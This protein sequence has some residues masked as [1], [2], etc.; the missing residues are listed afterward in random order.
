MINVLV[1]SKA[2][3]MTIHRREACTGVTGV[4]IKADDLSL[5]LDVTNVSSALKKLQDGDYGE[6]RM[7]LEI[8]FGDVL[9]E[10]AMVQYVRTILSPDYEKFSFNRSIGWHC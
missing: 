4:E 9:F 2:K 5:K 6:G 10:H 3:R 8:D 1:D 7:W